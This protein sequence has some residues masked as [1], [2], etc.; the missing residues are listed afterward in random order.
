M[1]GDFFV[2]QA[3]ATSKIQGLPFIKNLNRLKG[4]T[5]NLL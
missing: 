1:A 2:K 3:A 5:A 4:N